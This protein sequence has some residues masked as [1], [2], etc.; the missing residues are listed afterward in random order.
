MFFTTNLS[1]GI[2]A[3]IVVR[4][5]TVERLSGTCFRGRDRALA[6]NFSRFERAEDVFNEEEILTELLDGILW[7]IQEMRD[8]KS[9]NMT[10]SRTVD[11]GAPVGWESTD[12]AERYPAEALEPFKPN[13]NSNALR[14]KL[15]RGDIR[16]PVTNLITFVF[17][18]R[19]ENYEWTVIIHSMYPGEDIGNL[20][21]NVTKRENRVFFSWEHPGA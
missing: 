14:V 5:G 16:A 7:E 4:H 18:I 6:G 12:R 15:E 8:E 10:F 13:R 3:N 2:R 11:F 17:Q 9:R 1:N 21:G 19:K 20:K